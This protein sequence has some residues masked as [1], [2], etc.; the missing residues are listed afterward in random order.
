MIKLVM[1]DLNDKT[2][3]WPT[4]NS[5]LFLQTRLFPS[6]NKLNDLVELLVIVCGNMCVYENGI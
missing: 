2:F 1:R 4:E 3:V 6:F 5:Y